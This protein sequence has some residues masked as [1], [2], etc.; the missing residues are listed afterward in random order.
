M[1]PATSASLSPGLPRP[2]CPRKGHLK[3]I[4]CPGARWLVPLARTYTWRSPNASGGRES[5]ARKQTISQFTKRSGTENKTLVLVPLNVTSNGEPEAGNPGAKDGSVGHGGP[6]FPYTPLRSPISTTKKPAV[7]LAAIHRRR[8]IRSGVSA[9]IFAVGLFLV[10]RGS[11]IRFFTC[12]AVRRIG[13][14][15]SI[16]QT[17]PT[18]SPPGLTRWSMVTLGV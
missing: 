9:C 5:L 8:W 7:T 3:G 10:W 6:Q 17:E 11:Y 4:V 1:R 15:R 18:A 2:N 14:L 13:A 12:R 16:D